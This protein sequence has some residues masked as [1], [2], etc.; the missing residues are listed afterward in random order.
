MIG[1]K[2]RRPRTAPCNPAR[3]RSR[4]PSVPETCRAPR[5]QPQH[6]LDHPYDSDSSNRRRFRLADLVVIRHL[7]VRFGV[8]HV[9][10][11]ERLR[12]ARRRD[13]LGREQ[14][15]NAIDDRIRAALSERTIIVGVTPNGAGSGLRRGTSSAEPSAAFA[16]SSDIARS[17]SFVC[18]QMKIA[19]ASGERR[20]I[21][22]ERH[23]EP[24]ED[25]CL[26][27]FLWESA[28]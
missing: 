25:S 10:Q 1:P 9:L 13:L 16:S 20:H 8:L 11:I 21:K 3:N 14:N 19:V 27:L 26:N 12:T 4:P 17:G 15:R 23:Q 22:F 24:R 18:G 2:Y 6:R 28:G 7:L 5:R